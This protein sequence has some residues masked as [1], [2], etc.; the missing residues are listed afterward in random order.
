MSSTAL[1]LGTLPDGLVALPT[2]YRPQ[3]DT[4]LLAEALAREEP[5]PRRGVLGIGIGT[6]APTLRAARRGAAVTAVDVSWSAVASA[7]VNALFHRFPL[8]VRHGDFAASTTATGRR[9]DLAVAN[10]PYVPAPGVRLP[11]RGPQR[12]RD[13]SPDGRR[14]IDRIC[15]NASALLRPGGVL[16][17]VHSGMCGAEEREELVVIRAQTL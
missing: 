3:G 8:C 7:R 15:A 5:A 17:M 1:T 9:F 12:A 13:A 6:G 11:S 4:H 2:V 14:V 10:P 16:L